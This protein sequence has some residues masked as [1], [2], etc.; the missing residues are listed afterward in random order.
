M[1][2]SDTPFGSLPVL[3]ADGKTLGSSV[4]MARYVAKLANIV[5]E[6]P[7]EQAR[8]DSIVDSCIDVRELYVP[9]ALAKEGK[10]IV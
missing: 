7:I 4:A 2:L 6:G 8:L 5:G 1:L 3:E 10:V 9:F